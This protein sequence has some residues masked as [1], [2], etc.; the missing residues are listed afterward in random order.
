MTLNKDF[1]V[2]DDVD[3][4]LDFV[5]TLNQGQLPR[6]FGD[7][8]YKRML[9][10]K[11]R[12]GIPAEATETNG[13]VL[14]DSES[15]GS[16]FYA[17]VRLDGFLATATYDAEKKTLTGAMPSSFDGVAGSGMHSTLKTVA[18]A[19][20]PSNER[21]KNGLY[22]I[23]ESV[24]PT[25]PN[26]VLQ[27]L[28]DWEEKTR[29]VLIHFG[30][31]YQGKGVEYYASSGFA[32]EW[33]G[34]SPWELY[35]SPEWP[36]I[37]GVKGIYTA[38]LPGGT[39]EDIGTLTNFS[40]TG[41]GA[42]PVTH[43]YAPE[44]GDPIL[45]AGQTDK[46]QNGH[47]YVSNKATGQLSRTTWNYGASK[48]KRN[49][50]VLVTEG[51]KAGT[52]WRA[53]SASESIDPEN[54]TDLTYEQIS[55]GSTSIGSTIDRETLCALD[56]TEGT[57]STVANKS[58]YA[59]AIGMGGTL[60]GATPNT[61]WKTGGPTGYYLEIPAGEYVDID[62]SEQFLM[63][64]YEWGFELFFGTSTT[65]TRLFQRIHP[66][67]T[68]ESGGRYL[69]LNAN[70]KPEFPIWGELNYDVPG[71]SDASEWSDSPVLTDGDW[72]KAEIQTSRVP[73]TNNVFLAAAID[74]VALTSRFI[75]TIR[76]HNAAHVLRIGS[77]SNTGTL[78]VAGLRL[79]DFSKR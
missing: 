52:L 34:S 18:I 69:L 78:K 25:D 32:R 17:S 35:R 41:L 71:G 5:R 16:V 54:T 44:N 31:V 37:I 26:L 36:I 19:D 24:A 23:P 10:Q 47:W 50:L 33:R 39:L 1:R 20:A 30:S 72:H 40:L 42:L 43:G 59:P 76:D 4:S 62:N 13:L 70:G 53:V 12:A 63:D 11:Q 65:G 51:E 49:H 77:P 38:D 2:I 74:D 57:G 55:G 68:W 6:G 21:E 29:L 28:P 27:K 67:E 61:W 7:W 3:M 75:E 66:A 22:T 9:S 45:L 14:E 8:L 64:S 15:I 79:R 56:F 60:V 46:L 48:V 73:N 58:I